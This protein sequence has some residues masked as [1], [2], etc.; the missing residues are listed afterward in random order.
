MID[1]ELLHYF[2]SDPLKDNGEQEEGEEKEGEKVAEPFSLF[3][4]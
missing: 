1:E 4:S 3:L 2:L